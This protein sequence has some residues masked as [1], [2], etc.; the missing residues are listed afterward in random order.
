MIVMVALGTAREAVA[1][2]VS[3]PFTVEI[4]EE[5][6]TVNERLPVERVVEM[7]ST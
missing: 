2:T 1:I 3:Y 4:V 5:G 6:V 7:G